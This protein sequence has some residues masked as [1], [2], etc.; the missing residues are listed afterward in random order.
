MWPGNSIYS[1]PLRIFEIGL[2]VFSASLPFSNFGMSL[3]QIIML[4]AW[5]FDG[6]LISKI[7]DLFRT[8]IY[9]C[10][11]VIFF[12]LLASLIMG[13]DI[14]YGLN[15][16]RVKL[17]LLIFPLVFSAFDNRLSKRFIKTALWTFSFAVLLSFLVSF[18]IQNGAFEFYPDSTKRFS[19]FISHI[20]LA[21]MGALAV[22]FFFSE[23]DNSK[24]LG[25]RLICVVSCLIITSGLIQFAWL[26]GLL[27]LILVFVFHSFYKVFTSISRKVERFFW[28]VAALSPFVFLIAVFVCNADFFGYP[29][30]A[31]LPLFE[32]TA[33]GRYFEQHPELDFAENGYR[34]GDNIHWRELKSAYLKRTGR[35]T[36]SINP[37]GWKEETVLIRYLTSKNLTKD[38]TGVYSLTVNDLKNIAQG[39]PNYLLPGKDNFSIKFYELLIDYQGF[40]GGYNPY[41]HTLSMRIY[42]WKRALDIVA[43]NP[44]FGVGIGGVKLAFESSYQ[45]DKFNIPP[46]ARIRAHN[47]FLTLFVALGIPAGLLCLFLIFW[48]PIHLRKI[49]PITFIYFCL[50]PIFS[51]L[52][53]DSLETQAGVSMVLFAYFIWIPTRKRIVKMRSCIN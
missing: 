20:R 17:P 30:G 3:G 33:N 7:K 29:L 53:E 6:A 23:L 35:H 52:F 26:S 9:Y 36:D 22:V 16:L 18:F 43:E 31:P 40:I 37:A 14:T 44:Y 10:W 25:I 47:Q 51:M 8:P 5:I 28:S 32:K 39:V 19:P 46:H 21:M 24:S 41:G 11:T 2:L 13:G 34:F 45:K 12:L 38:S 50:L 48:P 15:D 42:A 4:L 1:R 27:A 49:L